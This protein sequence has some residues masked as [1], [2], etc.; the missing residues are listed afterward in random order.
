MAKLWDKYK[1][2][3]LVTI[4]FGSWI[5]LGAIGYFVGRYHGQTAIAEGKMGLRW[6]KLEN[7]P[8]DK[9]W[10]LVVRTAD[11][12]NF[13]FNRD[14]NITRYVSDEQIQYI[15]ELVTP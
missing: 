15:G 9:E 12:R 10:M 8:N 4:I 6:V 11:E 5:Y 1:L 3:I 2:P 13:L 14:K 7:E